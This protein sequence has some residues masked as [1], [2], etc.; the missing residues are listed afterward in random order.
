MTT[1]YK[2]LARRLKIAAVVVLLL[3]IFSADGVYWLGTR[4]ADSSD[5]LMTRGYDKAQARQAE[6]LYGRQAVWIKNLTDDLKQ[7]GTQAAI[8]LVTSAFIAAGCFYIARLID[9]G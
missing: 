1:S 6:F 7:P 5:A 4:S 8:I 9:E 2:P 3:G